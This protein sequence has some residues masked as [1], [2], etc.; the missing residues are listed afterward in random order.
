MKTNFNREIE[1]ADGLADAALQSAPTDTNALFAKALTFGL[2]AD[3]AALIEKQDVAALRFTKQGR[4]FADRLTALNPEAYDAYLGPGVE[5]YLL[6]FK[7][8]PM[9]ALLRITGSKVDRD[10]GLE[11]LRLTA[12]HGYYLE[13]FA[14]ILLAVAALRD[15]N[16]EVA[17]DL[18]SGLHNRFP[19]NSLYLRELNRLTPASK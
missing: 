1:S 17:R 18:F 4:S 8:A 12:Q 2:R 15:S 13:P 7:A 10:K 14:K 5:N 6:S 19:N 16:R 3:L 11:D 9:R